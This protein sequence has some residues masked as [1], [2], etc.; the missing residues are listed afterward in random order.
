[1]PYILRLVGILKCNCIYPIFPCGC[2]C[3]IFEDLS[4][5]GLFCSHIQ[6][7]FV[8]SFF[9]L[10]CEKKKELQRARDYLVLHPEDRNIMIW[11]CLRLKAKSWR[12]DL[13]SLQPSLRTEKGAKFT[14]I[15]NYLVPY[16][17]SCVKHTIFR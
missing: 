15:S 2:Y 9:T 7:I 12:C 5:K 3:A 14:Y 13:K 8:R 16:L 1:M 17:E 4:N 11:R 6:D 10:L